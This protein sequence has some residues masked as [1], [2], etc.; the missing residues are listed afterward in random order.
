MLAAGAAGGAGGR[1][2]LVATLGGIAGGR[3]VLPWVESRVGTLRARSTQAASALV[4]WSR[5]LCEAASAACAVALLAASKEG[6]GGGAAGAA[7]GGGG[8]A[9]FGARTPPL[10][11]LRMALLGGVAGHALSR[12]ACRVEEVEQA[13]A[14]LQVG[15]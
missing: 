13:E 12:I 4:A 15:S 6:A 8:G 7:G 10:R 3:L 11:A 2:T 14:R 5:P 1:L 9:V